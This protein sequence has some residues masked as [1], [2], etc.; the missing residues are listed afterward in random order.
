MGK[1][2]LTMDPVQEWGEEFE[3]GA[4][5][6][7]TLRREPVQSP[8]ETGDSPPCVAFVQYRTSKVRRL[9]AA[10]LDRI[11]SHLL[12]PGCQEQDYG[13][14][15]LST[16]RTFT[17][18]S[19]LIELL[20]HR[21]HL[22]SEADNIICYKSP[23]QTLAHTWLEECSDDLW[24]PPHHQ[25]LRYLLLHLRQ[26]PCLHTLA[27]RCEA[28]M[29]K[30]QG[31]VLEVIKP[32]EE[33][34]EA[35]LELENPLCQGDFM[36]FSVTS[37]GEQLTQWDCELFMKVVPF[38]CLGSVWSQRDKEDVSP[39]VRATIAQFN[40]I[41]NRVITS[42]LCPSITSSPAC[43]CS[44]PAQRA[45][46]IEK[47]IRVAQEC[48]A[49]KNFSSLKAILSALQSN[50]IYRLRKS[51]ASVCRESMSIFEGLC[52]TLP[53]EN[54]VL[55]SREI[56][57]EDGS[58]P[59]M[60]NLSPRAS[61][62]CPMSRQM[63]TSN[64]V[65]PYLGTYLTVL[66]MLDTALP[67]TVEG[68][69]I[70]FEKRRREFEVLSQIRQLQGSCL[71]YALPRH[72]QVAAW[73][74]Q[75]RLL[76]DQESYELSRDLEPPL[77]AC[78]SSSWNHKTLTKKLSSFLTLN[79]GSKKLH[80]DQIS[81]SS[82]GSSGSEMEDFSNSSPLRL[83]SP[84]RSC[85]SIA[86]SSPSSMCSDS[87]NTSTTTSGSQS[88]LSAFPA[89]PLA[90]APHSP[91]TGAPSPCTVS[92]GSLPVYNRQ[93]DDSCIIR[94]SVECGDSSNGN[95]YK[96]IL[97]TSQDKTVQVIQRALEK[98]NLESLSKE[99]FTLSQALTQ[100]RELFIPD[101]ANVYYAMSTSANY[102]FVLRHC[103]KG[104]RKPLVSTPSLG[105]LN[106]GQ[107]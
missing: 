79:E 60:D 31:Q 10:T 41:T 51:W 36:D 90:A 95:M 101:K 27:Q 25:G 67:D 58:Q 106:G 32:Q 78:P 21:R 28:L 65:V 52:E 47:W 76:S 54:C 74:Q 107:K 1:W 49:L 26:H 83:E 66:T 63:S 77:D 37:I 56:L 5:Y 100:D 13:Q 2:Q 44:S 43:R 17:D 68:G 94:V 97:L 55:T 40:A 23:L 86:D 39:T 35:E 82:S 91:S 59:P 34:E 4:V 81:V 22:T 14:I 45:R 33:P 104:N 64:G 12:D 93:V 38:Q 16:Y 19:S 72:P 15:L 46:A 99:D 50:P 75:P 20:F 61:K 24:D 98:H 80:T 18:T 62:Y 70:N 102:D 71:Q 30:F 89:S 103:P 105:L 8:A 48:R 11:V 7:I 6:G 85:Q 42:L 88:D 29:K 84:T 73:L 69:L 57:V 92:A 9:K 87:C 53:D 3:D 96:S